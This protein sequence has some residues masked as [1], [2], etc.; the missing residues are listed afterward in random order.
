MFTIVF[1]IISFLPIRVK[2]LLPKKEL[3]F[4]IELWYHAIDM[5][6]FKSVDGAV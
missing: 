6:I 1:L 4:Y 3:A 5:P 2:G